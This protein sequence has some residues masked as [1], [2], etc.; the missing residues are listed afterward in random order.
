MEKLYLVYINKVGTNWVGDYAY[1]FLFSNT[2]ENIDGED[3]DSYPASGKPTPPKSDMIVKVGRVTTEL[4][5]NVIQDS[6]TF[7]VWDAVDGIIALGWED[8]S[9]YE[10]YPEKRL[11]FKFGE[12]ISN[13]DDSLYEHDI[14]LEYK[15]NIK[16]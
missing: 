12:V 5:L 8:I 2:I 3:W 13:V 4:K 1:E 10:E 6:D 15:E 7:S 11:Y 9:E 16:N 14:V